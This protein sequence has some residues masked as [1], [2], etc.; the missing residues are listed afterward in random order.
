MIPQIIVANPEQATEAA[1]EYK[2]YNVQF[3]TP[4]EPNTAY[5]QNAS[6]WATSA[7]STAASYALESAQIANNI[8]AIDPTAKVDVGSVSVAGVGWAPGDTFTT[9]LVQDLKNNNT[10]GDFN[11]ISIHPYGGESLGAAGTAADIATLH[12]QINNIAGKPLQLDISE[13]GSTDEASTY[14][15]QLETDLSKQ[16]DIGMFDSYQWAGQ[17]SNNDAAYQIEGTPAEAALS[18]S[19]A[20]FKATPLSSGTAP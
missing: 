10:L 1:E 6:D 9:D 3:E 13:V 17:A 20:I 14:L 12:Q 2:G 16:S 7:A 11:A 8:H 15:P 4:N 5:D 19:N 18:A